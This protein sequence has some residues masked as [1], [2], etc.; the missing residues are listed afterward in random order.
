MQCLRCCAGLFSSCGEG[1][2]LSSCRAQASLVVDHRLWGT[3]NSVVVALG[4]QSIGS[5]VV[6]HGLSCSAVCEIFLDQGQNTCPVHWQPDSLPLD[7][8]E[9]TWNPVSWKGDLNNECIRAFSQ[10]KMNSIDN[11][12]NYCFITEGGKWRYTDRDAI[13]N[14]YLLKFMF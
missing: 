8:Q 13:V 6:V 4:L 12:N 14:Y 7:H 1:G 9:S 10:K 5:V 11:K 3:R 2:L